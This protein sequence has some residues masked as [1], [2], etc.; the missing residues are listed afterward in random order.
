MKQLYLHHLSTSSQSYT[1]VNEINCRLLLR[2]VA[3]GVY[4]NLTSLFS[5]SLSCGNLPSEWNTEVTPVWKGKHR[6][7]VENYRPVSV[8]P[9]VVKVMERLVHVQQLYNYLKHNS[10]LKSNQCIWI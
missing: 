5:Y 3:P 1:G 10:I 6:D 7:K 8:L 4:K 2:L 9:A